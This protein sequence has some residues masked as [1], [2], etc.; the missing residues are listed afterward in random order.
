MEGALTSFLRI[1]AVFRRRELDGA[2]PFCYNSLNV[3]YLSREVSFMSN[4]VRPETM[5][6]I[7]T[8][9]DTQGAAEVIAYGTAVK[10]N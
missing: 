9:D 3:F 10:F 7:T 1:F 2:V 8:P 6:R 5:E 4:N